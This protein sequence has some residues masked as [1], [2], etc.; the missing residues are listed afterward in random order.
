MKKSIPY[1]VFWCSYIPEEEYDDEEDD[2]SK[3]L[4]VTRYNKVFFIS[5]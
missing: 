1:R 5:I 2:V 4:A 3:L